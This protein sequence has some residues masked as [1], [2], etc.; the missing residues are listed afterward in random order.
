VAR[1]SCERCCVRLTGVVKSNSNGI[2]VWR[3]SRY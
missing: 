2:E 1:C 3:G